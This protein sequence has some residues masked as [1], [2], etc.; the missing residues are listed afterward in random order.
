VLPGML[1][2]RHGRVVNISSLSGRVPVAGVAVYSATK[3]AL[4]GLTLAVRDE[5]RGSGVGLTVVLPTFVNTEMAAG[6]RLR[7]LPRVHAETVARAIVRAASARRQ[8]AIVTVPCW[9]SPMLV[10]LGLTPQP[11]VDA[12]KQWLNADTDARVNP[13]ERAIYHERINRLK[14]RSG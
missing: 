12:I 8:P 5:L 7:G 13:D 14:P 1:S 3:H 6:V 2:R 9:L 4:I 11:L 10:V